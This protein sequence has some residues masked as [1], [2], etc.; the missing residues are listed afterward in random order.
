MKKDPYRPLRAA[1]VFASL[2][3][4]LVVATFIGFGIGYK[5][6]QWLHTTPWL[7]LVGLLLGVTAGFVEIIRLVNRYSND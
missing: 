5:L 4:L 6:D 3:I 2:G 1:G 7:S